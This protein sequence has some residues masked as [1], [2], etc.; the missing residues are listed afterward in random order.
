MDAARAHARPRP[1][2]RP[3]HPMAA[4]A[5][6]PRMNLWRLL[7]PRPPPPPAPRVGSHGPSCPLTEGGVLLSCDD[8]PPFIY[9]TSAKARGAAAVAGTEGPRLKYCG[10][11]QAL[12]ARGQR[13]ARR[14]PTA[15]WQTPKAQRR[16]A[17]IRDRGCGSGGWRLRCGDEVCGHGAV[18]SQRRAAPSPPRSPSTRSEHGYKG[19][20]GVWLR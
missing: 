12:K 8:P 3:H 13:D 4:A 1:P 19:V 16:L 14:R 5:L 11:P 2:L 15:H 17:L 18:V 9:T 7:A 10:A 20:T 6:S